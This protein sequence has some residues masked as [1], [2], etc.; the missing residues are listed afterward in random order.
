MVRSQAI[1]VQN[2][3]GRKRSASS[4][5]LVLI[6][7]S[8]FLAMTGLVM[9]A[10]SSISI[11]DNV[12]ANPLY[13]FWRQ[14]IS[15]IIGL[16]AALF[17]VNT[18]LSIWEKLSTYF[19]FIG[20]IFLIAVLVPGIGKEVN[21]SMRWISIGP[22]NLQSSELAKVCVILYLAGYMIR[23]EEK[24]RTTF[25]GFIH[26]IVIVT[27]ISSLLLLEPDYGSAVVLF[28][29]TLGMLFMGGVPLSRFFIWVMT[30]TIALL[31]L[32][33]LSP[34]RL[35]RLTSFMDPW[36]DPFNT[37]F[38]L[39]QALIAFGRGDWLGVGLGSS[40]QKLF[41]LPEAHTDFVFAVMAEEFGLLGSVLIIVL[42]FVLIWRS[43]L[44]GDFAHK[45]GRLFSAYLA[46]GIGLVI[47][48]QAF[49]NI[50]VNMGVLPTKGL[51]LPLIS[52]GNNSIIFTA[53]LI[54]FLVRIELENR[55]SKKSPAIMRNEANVA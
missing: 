52:Y 51:T 44:I 20:F 30:A 7:V 46:Y 50:G 34:Y 25:S 37:G 38:Q 22:I 43:F 15:V 28:A 54:A 17:I 26:P 13:Y 24:L 9:V 29:T 36:Q 12:H 27:L 40:I 3:I 31:S 55:Q 6:S 18:P 32:A 11:A 1:P 53:I 14:S 33:V 47:G 42:Y 8:I 21:G 10:S 41:Y 16:C 48:I 45:A 49:I 39:S 4:Y 35:Q 2:T 19:L 23:H 5:D